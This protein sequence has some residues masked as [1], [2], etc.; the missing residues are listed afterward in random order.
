MS[1]LKD[2]KLFA[3]FVAVSS[4]IIIAGII[5]YALLGFNTMADKLDGYRID[6][7]YNVIIGL[8][9]KEDALA[10]VCEDAFSKNGVAYSEKNTLSAVD[11]SSM[12]ETTDEVLTYTFGQGVSEEA[13]GKAVAEINAAVGEGTEFAD[14]EVF[15]RWHSLEG[16]RFYDSA[17]RGAIAIAVAAIVA[18]GYVCIRFGVSCGVAGFV[19]CAHDALFTAALLAVTRFPVYSFAPVLYAAIAAFI[20][21][22]LWLI[23]AEKCKKGFKEGGKAGEEIVRAA[24]KDTFKSVLFTALAFGIGIVA[25]GAIAAGGTALAVLPVLLAVGVPIYSTHFIAPEICIL[26]RGAIEKRKEKKKGGYVGKKKAE[27]QAE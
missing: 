17:W 14:A 13:L 23:V 21:V 11:S 22:I 4:V 19:S 27:N 12:N 6:V 1:K 16:E 20:S 9:D 7:N 5:L 8:N 18:L 15:A 26:I 10:K 24:V 3:I 2:N 25:V